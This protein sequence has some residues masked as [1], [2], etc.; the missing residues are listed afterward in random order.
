MARVYLVR[1]G[2]AIGYDDSDPGLSELGVTQARIVAGRL[3]EIVGTPIDIVT[4]PLRRARQTAQ[5]LAERWSTPA[6]VVDAVRELPSPGSHSERRPWLRAALRSTFAELGEQQREWRAEIL[7]SLLQFT[8]DTAV[9][10]HAVVISAV[11]GYLQGDDRVL[12]FLPV[13]TSITVVDAIDGQL[14]LVDR[15]TGRD[16]VGSVG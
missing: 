1:H 4:S 3:D 7:R 13:N 10:T 8:R 6:R 11:V 9:F 12:S 14:M 16:D 2:E 5:P 15:G